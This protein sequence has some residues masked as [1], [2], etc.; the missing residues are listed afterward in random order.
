[1]PQSPRVYQHFPLPK[2]AVGRDYISPTAAVNKEYVD[3]A[4]SAIVGGGGAAGNLRFVN[5]TGDRMVG[6]LTLHDDPTNPMEAATK[7]YIDDKVI[8]AGTY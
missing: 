4:I 2:A 8:D 1:M 6:A 5:T 3:N 7:Q